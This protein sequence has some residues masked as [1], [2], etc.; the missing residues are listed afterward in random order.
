MA[1]DDQMKETWEG[2]KN[3][4]YEYYESQRYSGNSYPNPG[5]PWFT[6]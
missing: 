6:P 2:S 4:G 3:R 5:D 1:S